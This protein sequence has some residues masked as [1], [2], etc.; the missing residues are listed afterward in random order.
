MWGFV[1]GFCVNQLRTI[2]V[3]GVEK[4]ADVLWVMLTVLVHGNDPFAARCS[5]SGEGGCM[6]TEVF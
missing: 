4:S 6:L 2:S 1:G 3:C 5:Y